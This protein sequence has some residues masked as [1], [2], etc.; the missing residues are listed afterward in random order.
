[1]D[2]MAGEITLHDLL[3]WEPRIELVSPRNRAPGTPDLLDRDVDWVLT[4]RSSPPMLPFLRGGELII[5][6]HRVVME[7]GLSFVR[8]VSEITMQ[9]VAGVLTEEPPSGIPDSPLVILRTPTIGPDFESDLNR[10]ITSRRREL[11]ESAADVDR[12]IADARVTN[13]RPAMLIETLAKHL[14]LPI[15]IRTGSGAILLSAG[16]NANQVPS[17]DDTSRTWLSALLKDGQ[18]IHIGPISPIQHALGRMVLDRIR[19][20]IQRALDTDAVTAPQG[21]QRTSALNA[22]LKPAAGTTRDHLA[23]QAFRAGIAPGRTLRVML[24]PADAPRTETRR[25]A[26]SLGDVLDAGEIH[27]FR[28]TITIATPATAK[29]PR[30]TSSH[31]LPWVA[32]S[33]IINTAR[34]FPEATRQAHYLAELLAQGLLP[35]PIVHFT[36]DTL[37]G[38]YRLLYDHWGTPALERYTTSLLGDLLREDRRGMLV[39]TLRVFLEFGGSHRPTAEKLGIHRNTLSYRLK[40]IRSI[41]DGD[42]NDPHV[43]LSMLIALVAAG[44]PPR[45]E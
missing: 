35:G 12:M 3:A 2:S 29:H 24:T 4:A 37:L 5:L 16:H 8:L 43:Q 42:L 26:S 28:A 41:V 18:S 17:S 23:D 21:D 44:L 14:E 10:L 15:S 19:D 31:E 36:D 7:T 9:P 32:I 27:G 13:A 38:T 33:N 30:L 40:Q 25:L 20:G 39:T 45:P 22:L 11:L 1:M 34:D 6:P